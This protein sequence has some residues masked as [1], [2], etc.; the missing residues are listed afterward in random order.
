MNLR[1]RTDWLAFGLAALIVASGSL[2]GF[3]VSPS[4]AE[5][6]GYVPPPAVNYAGTS[7]KP[8]R[9]PSYTST[10][11]SGTNGFACASNGCRVDLGTGANDYLY[12]DGTSILT[13]GA[14]YASGTISGASAQAN[15]V[16][17]TN[18]TA[19]PTCN[20][21]YER[22]L[23]VAASTGGTGTLA[24]TRLCL[25]TSDGAASP[26]FVWQNVVSGTLGT[27]TTCNP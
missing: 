11:S 13:P 5:A 19:L 4:P 6:Q 24:R 7:S 12:S 3:L 25:C 9:A 1:S 22:Y 26:A 20:S 16:R 23:Y 2:L 14:M 18:A 8:L 10:A 27:A 17:L 15:S 21:T